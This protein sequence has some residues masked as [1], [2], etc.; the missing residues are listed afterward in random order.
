[1]GKQ[2]RARKAGPIVEEFH[3]PYWLRAHRDW[4]FWAGIA[5]ML[6]M[7]F[8]YISMN[9]LAWWPSRSAGPTPVISLR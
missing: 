7:M 3:G 5:L 8:A 2:K 6:A 9:N 1:M 4:R